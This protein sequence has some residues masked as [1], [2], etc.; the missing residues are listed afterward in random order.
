MLTELCAAYDLTAAGLRWP[1]EG[2]AT[3]LAD[4][5]PAPA[6]ALRVPVPMPGLATGLLWADGPGADDDF[7]RLAANV[8]GASAVLRH[9]LGPTADQ[10][11]VAQRLDDAA[12][13]AGR[14]A[15]DMDNVFQGVTG[16]HA[17]AL[18]LM[19]PGST[20][21][22]NVREADEAA[23][24]GMRFCEQLHLLSRGGNARPIPAAVPAVLGKE[25]ERLT[26]AFPGVRFEVSAPA[27]L[28][29]VAVEDEKLRVILGNLL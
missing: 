18:E 1:A 9:L 2:P 6:T 24:K 8:L 13:V 19:S 10:A 27:G 22:Q 29:D 20:A 14:V 21:Y 5:G 4:T 7:V 12:R 26:R 11:R 3:L 16:F 25:I 28:P 23:K 17:L 15:H